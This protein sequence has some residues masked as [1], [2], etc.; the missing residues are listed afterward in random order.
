MKSERTAALLVASV[1][2]NTQ[3]VADALQGELERQ[4]WNVLH[5]VNRERF[6]KTV[7]ADLYLVGF[8]CRKSSMDDSS[9]RLVNQYQGKPM[10]V[11]GTMGNYPTGDYADLVRGNVQELVNAR[12]CCRG[13][14]LCQ[15]KIR[16]ERTEARRKLSPEEPHYLDDEGYRRHLESRRHPNEEDLQNAVGW[17]KERLTALTNDLGKEAQGEKEDSGEA[18]E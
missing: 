13:V 10:L 5:L 15:G 11:F 14:F 17:L 1:T 2:G 3:K 9:R 4:G 8:W 6:E 18:A 12:N 7:E 16:E